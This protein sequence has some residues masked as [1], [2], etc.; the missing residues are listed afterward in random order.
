MKPQQNLKYGS[1]VR[2]QG[3]TDSGGQGFISAKGFFDK[4]VYYQTYEDL[5][6]LNNF[7]EGLFQLL[8]R[9]SFEIHD[10]YYKMKAKNKGLLY[11]VKSEKEQYLA[12][13]E[14][15]MNEELYFGAEAIFKHIESGYYLVSSDEC[16]DQRSDSFKIKLQP[17]LSSNIIFKLE[18]CKSHQKTG[19][20]IQTKEQ[21]KILSDSSKFWL[22]KSLKAPV[23]LD[24]KPPQSDLRP[25]LK[26]LSTESHRYELI[27]SHNSTSSWKIDQYQSYEEYIQPTNLL[28]D[29]DICVFN[30][31][32]NNSYLCID[33]R[34]NSLALKLIDEKAQVPIDCL[35]E[36]TFVQEKNEQKSQQTV[37]QLQSK[38]VITRLPSV[39]V[40]KVSLPLSLIGL[41]GT[42]QSSGRTSANNAAA[43]GPNVGQL[44]Q[45]KRNKHIY[46]T[47]L[48]RHYLTGKLIKCAER[49]DDDDCIQAFIDDIGTSIDLQLANN[50]DQEF[51]DGSY[52]NLVHDDNTL[53]LIKI[54][55]HQTQQ[56]FGQIK[57]ISS[58]GGFFNQH[59]KAVENLFK[60]AFKGKKTTD[61]FIIKRVDNNYKT[62]L[63]QA[64]SALEYLINFSGALKINHQ[65]FAS[66]ANLEQI[67]QIEK[68]LAGLSKFIINLENDEEQDEEIDAFV[69]SRRQII[70]KELYYIEI[71]IEILYSLCYK[72]GTKKLLFWKHQK[73]LI[74]TLF[75]ETY[76][77][78]TKL[79]QNNNTNKTYASQWMEMYLHQYIMVSEPYIQRFLAE[80]LDN[81]VLA[82]KKFLN[83]NLVIRII[84]IIGSQVPHEKYLKILS[85]I[86]VSNGQP[87]K[88]N[89]SLVLQQFF[90]KTGFDFCFQFKIDEQ[91]QL[92]VLC[93]IQ[94]INKF[95]TFEE[96]YRESQ[97]IDSFQ[98][99]NYFQSYF[100][101]LGDICMKR[102]K[103]AKKYVDDNF[104]LQILL[105]ILI[106]AEKN[107]RFSIMRPLLKLIRYAY[108]DNVPFEKVKRIKRVQL[109]SDL[110]D[111]YPQ[112]IDRIESN[113]TLQ[114]FNL[115]ILIQLEKNKNCWKNIEFQ[116]TIQEIL[117][118]I[119]C[120]LDLGFY[121]NLNQ[122]EQI[123]NYMYQ[124]CSSINEFSFGNEKENSMLSSQQGTYVQNFIDHKLKATRL[125]E[126][127]SV[128]ISCKQLACEIIQKIFDF[129]AN[130]RVFEAAKLLKNLLIE[131]KIIE[132]IEQ[133]QQGSSKNIKAAQKIKT[134]F[135]SESIKPNAKSI[136]DKLKKKSTEEEKIFYDP[137]NWILKFKQ[138]LQKRSLSDVE[139][140][141]LIFAELSFYENP[142][143]PKYSLDILKRAYGQRKEL[144]SN[145]EKIIIVASG[146]T[147][148]LSELS[149]LIFN[150]FDILTDSYFIEMY[151]ENSPT[152]QKQN[153]IWNV[154]CQEAQKTGL[155]QNLQRL[156]KYLKKDFDKTKQMVALNYEDYY[157][158]NKSRIIYNERE[159]NYRLHQ[160]LLIAQE[161]HIPILNFI[162]M[163]V[164]TLSEI[165]WKLLHACYDYLTL[166]IWNH[167][168]N[169]IALSKYKESMYPHL[170]Y[171]VGIID[172]LKALFANNKPLIYSQR[173]I[174]NILQIILKQCDG[175]SLGN[176]Y[177]SKLL[178]FLRIILIFNS[179]YI[180]QNQALT[181]QNL[182]EHT[183][184]NLIIS[185][186][187][188]ASDIMATQ[189]SDQ[190]F[191]DVTSQTSEPII[192]N[193]ILTE[194]QISY[195]INQ[196]QLEY[197]KLNKDQIQIDISPELSYMYTFFGLFSQLVEEQHK[198][199]QKKCRK[200]H[201]FPDLI[202]LLSLS[203]QVWPLKRYLR[204][205][206]NRLYYCQGRDVVTQFIS[207][208]FITIL[209]DLENIIELKSSQNLSFFNQITIVNP[210]RY[211]Y[212]I[213][214]IYLYLEE[215]LI[216]LHYVFNNIEFLEDLEEQLQ[217]NRSK[218][219]LIIHLQIFDLVQKLILIERFYQKQNIGHISKIILNILHSIVSTFDLDILKIRDSL[220]LQVL[221]QIN[222]YE[223]A[224]QLNSSNLMLS[225]EAIDSEIRN[226]LENTSRFQHN[227]EEYKKILIDSI[228]SVDKFTQGKQVLGNLVK[229]WK[230]TR[231]STLQPEDINEKIN[232]KLKRVINILSLSSTF[233]IFLEEE[234]LEA[235]KKMLSIGQESMLAYQT[236][237]EVTSLKHYIQNIIH[238]SI[239]NETQ[240]TDDLR[241]F[242]L[243][244]IS[245]LIT[246]KNQANSIQLISVDQWPSDYWIDYKQEIENA[247]N[248]LVD[249][250]A[251]DLVIALFSEQKLEIRLDL[252]SECL[253]FLIAFLLG[254]NTKA[255]NAILEKL[256]KDEQNTV[257]TN[258]RVLISKLTQV[259]NNNFSIIT[260]E[261]SESTELIQTVDNYDFFDID[262]QTMIR[263]N[264]IDPDDA[265]ETAFKKLCLDVIC[266][267]FRV[268]QLFCENNNVEMKKYIRQQTDQKN[269]PKIMSTNFIEFA[270]VQLRVYFKILSKAII[271][272]P[273]SMLDFVNEVIQ[274]PCIDNQ[275][276]LCNTTFF[277]DASHMA[278]FFN[279]K[280]NQI[281]RLFE[282]SEDLQELQEL[283]NKILQA[284][285]SVLEGNEEKIYKDLSNKLEAQ[286]L[287]NFLQN[288]LE[289]LNIQNST[290]LEQILQLQDKVFDSDMQKIL[291]VCII[292]QQMTQHS[293]NKW[294][295]QFQEKM[296]QFPELPK[297]FEK[298]QNLIH[299]IEIIYQGKK[300]KVF[301]PFHPYFNL[302]SEQTKQELLFTVNRETQR[303][304]LVGMLS[305]SEIL[306]YE[307]EHNYKLNHYRIPIT[308]Q[309][310]DLLQNLASTFAVLINLAMIFFYTVVVKENTFFLY[311]NQ[312][313]QLIINLLSLGQLFSQI[314]LFIMVS[315]QRVPIAIE[316]NHKKKDS[317]L[318]Y[319]V[320]FKED[321]CLILLFLVII[322]FYGVFCNS[323]FYVIHLVEIFSRNS[324]LKNVFQAISYNAKQ[325]FVVGLLG[326]LFVFA[327]SVISF[328]V[329][330]DDIYQGEQTETCNSLITCMITLITSGV[331]GNSMINWDPLKFFFDMLFTV[332]FGLLFTNIIQGIMIDTFAELRDQRQKIEEDIKNKCFI[333]AAS[334]TDLEKMNISFDEHTHQLHY[335]W[336]YIFYVKCLKLKEWTE[337]TGLEYWI[338]A[339]LESDDITWFPESVNEDSNLSDQMS[340]MEQ[341]LS[342]VIVLQNE[343]LRRI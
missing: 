52:V 232:H 287:I 289:S 102:N 212:L 110:D 266:R 250:G 179:S 39:L 168:E 16:S 238:M 228:F 72:S 281:N 295:V 100:D 131:L 154:N 207:I 273:Q 186:N 204:A 108:I 128:K 88:E 279:D 96:F 192:E 53:T 132:N 115:F 122:I 336:N 33:L 140:F 257:L 267:F 130:L 316:K 56:S 44:T 286:F 50:H 24:H 324:L 342:D 95:R 31:T 104:P 120:Q 163:F 142:L 20:P 181:L 157:P 265:K 198:V 323:N 124:I 240:F 113:H 243:K 292:Q 271:V 191:S 300:M 55:Q 166:I 261:L 172:F 59:T 293:D 162:Q 340:K 329:Y 159:L 213:S 226:S 235:C 64:F 32:Q 224:L 270:S 239:S 107:Q 51:L 280:S 49:L 182:Q 328:N 82:I 138:L 117:K 30:F 15:K 296:E 202:K 46:K 109:F 85:S 339:K 251:A 317:L 303:D 305:Q 236:K 136:A 25:E 73:Q 71:L 167:M 205:Y 332:F 35:W 254:G 231:R 338:H 92:Q 309:N 320:F 116:K 325:L 45:Q 17:Y 331:I 86:C 12:M 60:T 156:N 121:V 133:K 187:L 146:K 111:E 2:I 36:I 190:S 304:K 94:K 185:L 28:Q 308:Q 174:P 206:I 297:I 83:Q 195:Y 299:K 106:E 210:I 155:I 89:Q 98:Q 91:S 4:A 62:E 285:L 19:R 65:Y 314:A 306:F 74:K 7:R 58:L 61:A 209:D 242:F 97:K 149:S 152:Y 47:I 246:E 274:L 139:Y 169:K 241:I 219:K 67:K 80:I 176:Y 57:D 215:I 18:A 272:I 221:K 311:S 214:Y 69:N 307:L 48:L 3:K 298:L 127:N 211:K 5:N 103:Q 165:Y 27:I 75:S 183:Y 22:E 276:T 216:T 199:N 294:L 262:T 126:S 230:N 245:K 123:L 322:S 264:V 63:V 6:D 184:G 283:Q 141:E 9:G 14:N 1:I 70:M 326:I 13:I 222:A 263:L 255:Q 252:L 201:S 333:C 129:E 79:I 319:I 68:L 313:N 43:G 180:P 310:L 268:M 105:K 335:M 229:I 277:E 90:L 247:Q 177:K 233:Q 194:D 188:V 151:N 135:T 193:L 54:N 77:L 171:N 301:F 173:E 208:D 161:L 38:P 249:C 244:M 87:V 225:S 76:S 112:Y 197:Q 78:L 327:F 26:G 312:I 234:F 175:Q 93:P 282:N 330:F 196:Y 147:L 148:E 125:S 237:F 203:Q 37:P 114:E 81:N 189:N 256:K 153:I 248:F 158:D 66:M 10:E 253:L 143:L 118:I 269:N 29:R 164:P 41:P 99:W 160:S 284:V 275:I 40:T 337:Y 258:F 42:I 101:L 334:R 144:I 227:E 200:I 343:I 8:P 137:Q 134:L 341:I 321:T 260:Q 150:K 290:D 259:I 217:L 23:Q 218:N 315:L 34:K 291:N 170:Q 145:F 11:R 223:K 220:F 119:G 84:E 21:V 288:N 278:Q 318:S 302:L 178:D